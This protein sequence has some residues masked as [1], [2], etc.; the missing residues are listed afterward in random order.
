MAKK[1]HNVLNFAVNCSINTLSFIVHFRSLS[2]PHL[3]IIGFKPIVVIA[4][5]CIVFTLILGAHGR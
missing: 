1:G 4:S 2:T 5:F 3:S